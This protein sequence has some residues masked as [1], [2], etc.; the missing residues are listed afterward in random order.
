[1]EI[2]CAPPA[3]VPS[4]TGEG[5][6]RL[7]GV[8]VQLPVLAGVLGERRCR[9]GLCNLSVVLVSGNPSE[10]GFSNVF[11]MDGPTWEAQLPIILHVMM[12]LVQ[13]G[14]LL[15]DFVLGKRSSQQLQ[16]QG[17]PR[18]CGISSYKA[19]AGSRQKNSLRVGEWLLAQEGR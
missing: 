16:L 5:F 8:A 14:L 4:C 9:N 12:R 11:P 17:C 3:S 6:S 10:G 15:Q 2:S 7:W 13:A 19:P 18:L 1:M